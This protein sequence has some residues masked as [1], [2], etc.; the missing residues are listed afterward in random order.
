MSKVARGLPTADKTKGFTIVETLIVL[1]VT[2]LLATSTLLLVSGRQGRTEFSTGVRGVESLLRDISND[3]ADGYYANTAGSQYLTC[4]SVTATS[5]VLGTAVADNQGS[6]TGCV[7]IGKAIQFAPLDLGS[8]KLKVITL[9]GRQFVNA[10]SAQG[11]VQSFNNSGGSGVYPAA[12]G[13]EI[14]YTNTPDT[15]EAKSLGGV[16]IECVL[17]ANHANPTFNPSNPVAYQKPCSDPT[18]SGRMLKVDT[19]AFMTSFHG[20]SLSNDSQSGNNQVNLVVFKQTGAGTPVGRDTKDVADE[21]RR[22]ATD[23]NATAAQSC[24]PANAASTTCINPPGGVFLCV[25]SSGSS[26]YALINI[27]GNT[28]KNSTVSDFQNGDC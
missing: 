15:S 25:Q 9:F 14:G 3:I 19:I 4:S 22:Y 10:S 2:S 27:G 26:Q 1:A 12:P 17:Y 18:V 21:L 23:V 6:N 24:N 16:T 5:V 11:D 28:S 7:V 8:N 20:T 13:R